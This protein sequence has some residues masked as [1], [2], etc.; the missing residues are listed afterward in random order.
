MATLDQVV[1]AVGSLESATVSGFQNLQTALVASAAKPEEHFAPGQPRPSEQFSPAEQLRGAGSRLLDRVQSALPAPVQ[2][3]IGRMRSVAQPA[4]NLYQNLTGGSRDREAGGGDRQTGASL[5]STG[6]IIV[7]TTGTVLVQG[8]ARDQDARRVGPGVGDVDP[9]RRRRGKSNESAL[10]RAATMRGAGGAAAGGAR[11]AAG[12]A[13]GAARIGGMATVAAGEAGAALGAAGAVLGAVGA[14][15]G[16]GAAL[17]TAAFAVRDMGRSALEAQRHLAQV[18]PSMAQVFAQSDYRKI[19]R[20]QNE[21]ERLA[22]SAKFLAQHLDDL[23]D[24]LSEVKVVLMKILNYL[25]GLSSG[26][27]KFLWN[28]SPI[29]ALLKLIGIGV[30]KIANNTEPKAQNMQEWFMDIMKQAEAEKMT[31]NNPL[32]RPIILR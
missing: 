22:E 23:S 11:A 18:S 13:G 30:D 31:G 26:A 28:S 5:R 7:R 19:I 27:V 14:V 20:E 25:L 3:F 8:Q 17:I 6:P 1:A 4:L 21:G 29:P 24:E 12:A 2:A 15:V 9:G 16:F 10:G 32:F